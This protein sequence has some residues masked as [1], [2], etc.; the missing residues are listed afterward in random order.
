[1]NDTVGYI[2][3]QM[4]N[5]VNDT[6]GYIVHQIWNNVN[7]TVGYIVHQMWNNANDTVGYI[8]DY[9]GYIIYAINSQ[10]V[11]YRILKQQIL[12]K[13]MCVRCVT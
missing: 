2:V 13:I 7:D 12:T 1:V 11:K 10:C 5:N 3:H 4:W 9:I 6:V 8:G